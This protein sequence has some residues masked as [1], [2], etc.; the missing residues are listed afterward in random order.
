[1]TE[2]AWPDRVKE[3]SMLVPLKLLSHNITFLVIAR[4][5]PGRLQCVTCPLFNLSCNCFW[6][7]NDCKEKADVT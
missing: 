4:Q 3:W 1:M 7:C 5:V 6:A 2:K